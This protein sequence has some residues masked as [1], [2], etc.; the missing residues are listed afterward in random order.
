MI[1]VNT[2]SEILLI[3]SIHFTTATFFA[4][5]ESKHTL[6]V[7][8]L[9]FNYNIIC[10]VWMPP[11][12]I[13]AWSNIHGVCTILCLQQLYKVG[14]GWKTI[15]GPRRRRNHTAEKGTEPRASKS[16]SNP[17]LHI[18]LAILNIQNFSI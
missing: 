1:A 12:F 6:A 8:F 9:C 17:A 5:R 7:T 11:F 10:P 13:G 16:K 14:Y 2:C 15:A 3:S 18:T 4:G